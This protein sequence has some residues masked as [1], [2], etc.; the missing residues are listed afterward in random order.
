MDTNT[1]RREMRSLVERIKRGDCVLVLGPRVAIRANDPDR[2]PLDELLACV[3]LA[4]IDAHGSEGCFNLRR[5][6]DLYYIR[7]QD[8]VELELA[9]QDFYRSEG[10]STTDFHR[11]LAQL[12][13]RLCINASPDSLMLTAFKEE[14]KTPQSGYYSFRQATN[15]RLSSPTLDRPLVYHLFGHH[16]NSSSLVLT[17]GDLIE[18]LVSIIRGAPPHPGPGSQHSGRS[19]CLLSLYRVRFPQLVSACASPGNEGIWPSQ[20][21]DCL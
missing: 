1:E 14:K 13:F 3:L 12:P 2:R 15:A 6:A 9:V 10:G 19:R 5:A 18:F 20:Q 7:C 8:R 16:E 4:S 21:G 11:D 17:E